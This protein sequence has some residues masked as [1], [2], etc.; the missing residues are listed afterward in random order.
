MDIPVTD[1]DWLYGCAVLFVPV[2][3]V[4][5][6]HIRSAVGRGQSTDAAPVTE[7]FVLYTS[8]HLYDYCAAGYTL[9]WTFCDTVLENL[10]APEQWLRRGILPVYWTME[11]AALVD[12][13]V[14][15]RFDVELCVL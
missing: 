10:R 9:S 11:R 15:V 6:G 8:L 1:T 7:S 4:R 14:G 12:D 3:D 2:E 5:I 13:R